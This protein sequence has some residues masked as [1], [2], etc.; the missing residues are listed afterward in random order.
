MFVRSEEGNFKN[1]PRFSSISSTVYILQIEHED[2][3]ALLLLFF[4]NLG[5]KSIF[6]H[7]NFE[8]RARLLKIWC[9]KEFSDNF[10]ISDRINFL[11]SDIGSDSDKKSLSDR[12]TTL[13]FYYTVL[14]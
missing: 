14:W 6:C 2:F 1:F 10:R 5:E 13:Q 7:R 12:S 11:S 9:A 4:I 3:L 8:F